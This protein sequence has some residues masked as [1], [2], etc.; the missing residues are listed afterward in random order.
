MDL[1]SKRYFMLG[2]KGSGMSSL[3]V[4]LH[5][6]GSCVTGCDE[7][8]YFSTEQIL[9]R[10]GIEYHESFDASNLN[11]SIETVIFSSAYPSD[12]PI[13]IKALSLEMQVYSYPQFLALLSRQQ[14]S[15]AVAG[16]H[17][18]STTTTVTSYLL[19]V[20][21]NNMFPFYTVCGSNEIGKDYTV[22]YGKD[23][24]LF[25][26]CEYQDH[27]LLYALR[28]VLVTNIEWDHPDYFADVES[29]QRSFEILVDNLERGG[30]FIYCADDPQAVLLAEYASNHR[31]DLTILSYG[32]ASEGPFKIRRTGDDLYSVDL[33][34]E[35]HFPLGVSEPA[36]VDN[37]IGAMV[38]SLCML[39]DRPN[40]RLYFT[41]QDS[42]SD[43]IVPSL[44]HVMSSKLNAF[45]GC[46][47]RTE[48]LF[49]EG[50]IIYIDDYAH[51]PSEIRTSLRELRLSYPGYKIL[52]IFCLHTASRTKALFEGF[53]KQLSEPDA[54]IIQKTFASARNDQDEDDTLAKRLASELLDA[55]KLLVS[56]KD[57]DED[58]VGLAASWLQERWLCITMGAG[59]NR[60]LAQRIARLHRSK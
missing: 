59:N 60:F 37:H 11:S 52:V 47:G 56:Y 32:F 42:V 22:A 38:L 44:V 5:T 34:K 51:H 19:S 9:K 8:Q 33:C 28:G 24:A 58:V 23:C 10:A 20:V 21:S 50:N 49:E 12:H 14:D 40:P 36:L 17:G 13:L 3:A 35:R 2:I 26:A 31:S 16:T 43:E 46:K 57:A 25:E 39:L 1:Y 53:V 54:L 41:D 55:N 48:V 4:L 29:V 15:Y 27:F 30:F 6:F 18:K 45:A 7:E